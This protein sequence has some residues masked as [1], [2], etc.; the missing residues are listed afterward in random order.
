MNLLLLDVGNTRV[1]WARV[2]NGRLGPQR[3]LAHGGELRR[4]P[5]AWPPLAAGAVDQVVLVS[6]ASR[7][8][9]AAIESRL[10]RR[11]FAITRFRSRATQAGLRNAYREPWRLGADRWAAML[12]A[13]ARWPRRALL[14]VSAGTAITVDLVDATGRHRGGVIVP[15]RRLMQAALLQD[16][17][18]IARRAGRISAAHSRVRQPFAR[19]TASALASGA[20]QAAVAL[21]ERL[22]VE[23]RAELGHYPHVVLTGGDAPTL[24][25]HLKCP[26][27]SMQDLVL[28]GL[29]AAAV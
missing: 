16:T 22:R 24:A 17:A 23:A 6:V 26:S 10:R 7:H 2:R 20:V 9:T 11:G 3:A 28:R 8:I 4:L 29:F 18:G 1:K 21:V 27:H 12:G 25:R 13:R 5:A 14:V 15:G 19:H